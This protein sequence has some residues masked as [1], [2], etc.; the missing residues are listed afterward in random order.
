MSTPD[1]GTGSTGS[2]GSANVV[3]GGMGICYDMIATGGCKTSDT[4]NADFGFL[5]S[6][7]FAMVRVY[8]I[9]CPVGDFVAAAANQGMKI[10]VG[11]NSINMGDMNTLIG[12]VNG[13]WA[14]V[15]TVYVGNERVNGNANNP[16]DVAAAVT[17]AR[18]ILA[19]AG[20]HGNVVT[21]DTFNAIQSNPTLISTSDYVCANAHAFF[22]PTGAAAQA[23]TFVMN[24][25]KAV[26]GVAGG[27]RVVIS[28]TGWPWQGP[29][30]GNACPSVANQQTAMNGIMSEFASM[31]GNLFLFQGY[32]A[33]YKDPGPY[34]VE[35]FFGIFD[36]DHYQQGSIHP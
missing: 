7:G 3:P 14:P 28:E 25:Y 34:G 2:Q 15:D 26:K 10:M 13:N 4:I 6:Q 30:N 19:G 31:A 1:K 22:D 11:I 33:S 21:V 32:D 9:G 27:K 12:M 5:R 8:D 17:T 20:Y 35:Q 16:A 36:S 24:A 23:A 29:C 18:G